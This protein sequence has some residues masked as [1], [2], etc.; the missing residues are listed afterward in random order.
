VFVLIDSELERNDSSQRL[1]GD[2]P[3]YDAR[4]PAW[5]KSEPERRSD[6]I[7]RLK[8]RKKRKKRRKG[9]EA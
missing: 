7:E 3:V 8:E 6:L 4:I 2:S 9:P 5:G 1:K